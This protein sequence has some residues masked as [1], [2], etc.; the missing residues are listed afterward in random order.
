[1]NLQLTLYYIHRMVIKTI[2]KIWWTFMQYGMSVFPNK[3][4]PIMT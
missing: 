2:G 3:V 1:M 4:V